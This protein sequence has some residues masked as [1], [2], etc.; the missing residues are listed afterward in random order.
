M[1]TV[2]GLELDLE[3]EPYSD[4]RIEQQLPIVHVFQPAALP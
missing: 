3:E 2:H 4:S 1:R